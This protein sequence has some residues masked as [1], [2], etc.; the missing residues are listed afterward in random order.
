MKKSLDRRLPIV[1]L[2]LVCFICAWSVAAQ[3]RGGGAP[4]VPPHVSDADLKLPAGVSPPIRM[5]RC[6]WLRFPAKR[7]PLIAKT[8]CNC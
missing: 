3:G 2:S 7:P 5:D 6:Q 8:C 1:P 4:G